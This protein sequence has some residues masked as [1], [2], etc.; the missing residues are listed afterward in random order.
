LLDFLRTQV[1]SMSET[2]SLRIQVSSFEAACRMVEAGVGVGV[3]P[4]SAARRH[5]RT[6]NLAVVELNEAWAVRER[7]ILVRDLQTL[8][9]CSKA[10]ISTIAPSASVAAAT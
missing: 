9:A 8:P 7:S 2:I 4:E 6:V 3:I 1:E 5:A 10:L